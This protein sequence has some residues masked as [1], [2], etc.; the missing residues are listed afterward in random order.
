MDC[1]DDTLELRR[2]K[3]IFVK[4]GVIFEAWISVV[5]KKKK[6]F[7][8]IVKFEKLASFN[9]STRYG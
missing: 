3:G 5:G 2:S 8:K 6:G 1:K 4:P 7:E 9:D